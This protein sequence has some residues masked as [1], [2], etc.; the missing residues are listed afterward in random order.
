MPF[1]K[2]LKNILNIVSKNK[3]LFILIFIAAVLRLYQLDKLTIFLSD[4]GRDAIIVER[5]LTFKNFPLIGAPTSIGQVFLGPFYYYLI[6]PFLFIFQFNPAGMAYGVAFLSLIG[7]VL[8]YLAVKKKLGK[9]TAIFFTL[10]VVFS[11]TQIEFSRF[12]WN[13]N[14][15][16][17]FSFAS[18]YFFYKSLTT[19]NYFTSF[20]FGALLSFSIQLHYLAIFLF[21]P[22]GILF[23]ESLIKDKHKI[24]IL[25]NIFVTALSFILFSS[26]L[27]L[28]DLRHGFLNSK[29]F[30]KLFSQKELVSN[31]SFFSRF[32]DTVQAFI[33]HIFKT[34]LNQNG[35]IA[36]LL[37]FIVLYFLL[38]KKNNAGL[39]L[40][41]NFYAVC[42]YLLSFSL[43]SS[44][45]HP[46][47]FASIYYSFFLILGYLLSNL[48]K[49]Q[50]VKY[51]IPVLF[52]IIYIFLNAKNYY[53]FKN[54]DPYWSQINQAKRV[55][56]SLSKEIGN[57]PF[58]FATWPISFGEDNFLYFLE[59]KGQIAANREKL[60]ITD[61]M[62]VLC[63]E[64]P[65]LVINSPSWNISMFGKAKIDKIWDFEGIKIYKLIHEK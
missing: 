63:K 19:K 31:S 28:F 41:I 50:R 35:A 30:L 58:N 38:F 52:L 33:N 62:F 24:L 21:I 42:L 40:K 17:I 49:L 4:Q 18:L 64:E 12:S 55:A 51:I 36:V 10:L 7:I 26:T 2:V 22:L 23:L 3:V 20:I 65:C 6:A 15:L 14:L 54:A 43:L 59:L 9:L 45:R 5:I 11:F 37:I 1:G 61:Q 16:P 44:A 25:K 56:N 27:I 34:D 32:S 8:S 53:F 39:F 48:F 57:K 13:P 60:E 47:Y 29:N 46:H